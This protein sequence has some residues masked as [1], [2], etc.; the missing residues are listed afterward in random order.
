MK[1]IKLLILLGCLVLLL[2]AYGEPWAAAVGKPAPDF[3][4]VDMQGNARSLSDLR[5]KVVFVNFWATWCSSCR[6][7]MPSMQRL[8]EKMPKD[9]FE[10]IGL[11]NSDKHE[12]AKKFI[13]DL[14]LTFPIWSDKSN[15]IGA[16]Y[17]L[18]VLPATLIVDK[19]GVI[20]EKFIG[21]NEWDTPETIKMLTKY[22]NE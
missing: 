6:E 14:G 12:F 13:S 20:R 7:E 9:K 3:D 11:F 2:A 10:M 18:S 15:I 22:I 8:Y 17:G 4:T 16:R 1:K 5:G 21:P 19:Q